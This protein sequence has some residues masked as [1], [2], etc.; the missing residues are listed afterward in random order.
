MVAKAFSIQ[1]LLK[2]L[3]SVPTGKLVAGFFIDTIYGAQDEWMNELA[4]KCKQRGM[5][6]IALYTPSSF[7]RC[8][9]PH[10]DI[11]A[12]VE[13]G[14][15]ASLSGINV[16]IISDLDAWN[17][18][19][20]TSRVLG[21]VHSFYYNPV[22]DE[23]AHEI[24]FAALLDG[25]LIPHIFTDGD[26]TKTKYLW[27]AIFDPAKG[28]RPSGN[29]E[30][31]SCAYPR[32][33]VMREKIKNLPAGRGG[34]LYA[35]MMIAHS[36]DY[37]GYRIR[38]HGLSI[39][40][41]LLHEFPDRRVIFRPFHEDLKAG[42]VQEIIDFFQDEPRFQLDTS[43]SQLETFNDT[44]VVISDYSNINKSFTAVTGRPCI[45]FRPWESQTEHNPL[46]FA[47]YCH[48]Y[49]EL[50]QT[51]HS[52]LER[53]DEAQERIKSLVEKRIPTAKP[54]PLSLSRNAL[55]DLADYLPAFI[56][57]E[58]RPENISIERGENFA[59]AGEV[60]ER[61]EEIAT[62]GVWVTAAAALMYNDPTS[63]LLAAYSLHKGKSCSSKNPLVFN[64]AEAIG[65]ILG[66]KL[67]AKTYEDVDPMDVETLYKMA[68]ANPE[69]STLAKK[70]LVEFH[71][72]FFVKNHRTLGE[73]Q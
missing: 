13:N 45:Y 26:R 37:G 50:G 17:R 44:E 3:E 62:N 56:K 9:L 70:L 31:I 8:S 30:L 65:K 34:L 35:P 10:A 23:Y 41:Y 40:N 53:K 4:L 49:K 14:Q 66:K 7:G 54:H 28:L 22:D 15:L 18:Y 73:P 60:I 55:D 42:E 38:A 68:I 33:V 46:D 12:V 69:T 24:Q 63:P 5:L 20:L 61:C 21:C 71:E 19:P 48:S 25:L 72:D 11:Q 64:S 29:F 59:G 51:L 2:K 52:M 67:S 43:M 36:L 27:D 32:V 1:G 16:F 47:W 57:G 6:T 58:S 39:I